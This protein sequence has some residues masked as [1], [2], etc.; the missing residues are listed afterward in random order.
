M[1]PYLENF[2]QFFEMFITKVVGNLNFGNKVLAKYSIH[3]LKNVVSKIAKDLKKQSNDKTLLNSISLRLFETNTSM[4][5]HPKFYKLRSDLYETI[6]IGYLDDRGDDYI[7][8]SNQVFQKII[9]MN[10][11][12]KNKVPDLKKMMVDFIG[13]FNGISSP[14][15]LI[16]FAKISYP[17]LQYLLNGYMGEMINDGVFVTYLLGNT[18]FC[19]N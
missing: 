19:Y 10:W 14:K 18:L 8:N 7:E 3:V 9:N 6:S 2:Q 5:G 16:C 12:D 13:V 15:I 4:L 11:P 17:T 1:S